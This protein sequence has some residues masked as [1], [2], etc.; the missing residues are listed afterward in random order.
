MSLIAIAVIAY[1]LL[2]VVL[3]VMQERMVFLADLPGRA[4]EAT[5]RDIGLKR[6]VPARLVRACVRTARHGAVSA[7]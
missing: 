1:V 4:L 3:Y 2:G 6:R 5:P 7:R